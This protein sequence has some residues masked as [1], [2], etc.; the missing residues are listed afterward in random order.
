M[1]SV[2]TKIYY[3]I[4][5]WQ[6]ENIFIC[7]SAKLEIH[8]CIIYSCFLL[9]TPP[10][11]QIFEAI[12]GKCHTHTYEH[13]YLLLHFWFWHFQ[14]WHFQKSHFQIFS[15]MTLWHFWSTFWFWHFQ[16]FHF[17]KWHFRKCMSR[18]LEQ[19]VQFSQFYWY[20]EILNRK[21]GY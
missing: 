15:K 3:I 20:F 6:N 4:R 21:T 17:R 7:V 19:Y 18:C 5:M 16:E 13:V 12:F 8:L 10:G 14:E 1:H 11:G 2:Y 9:V